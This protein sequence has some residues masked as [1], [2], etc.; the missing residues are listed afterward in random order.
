MEREK[1]WWNFKKR[2]KKIKK[3]NKEREG[4]KINN[5]QKER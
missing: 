1:K 4:K 3:K 5:L 2:K